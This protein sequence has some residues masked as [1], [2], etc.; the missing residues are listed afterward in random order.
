VRPH[1]G[2]QGL[3]LAAEV[4]RATGQKKTPEAIAAGFLRIRGENPLDNSA[5]HPERYE[6]VE[7]MA[8]DL[9]VQVGELVGQRANTQR[10]RCCELASHCANRRAPA[11][12]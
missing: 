12:K 4:E 7:Q 8:R 10:L 6:V 5:V 2:A 1:G 11:T 9:G 3:Q